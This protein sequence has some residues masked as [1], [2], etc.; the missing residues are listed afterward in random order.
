[1]TNTSKL[2]RELRK[3]EYICKQRVADCNSCAKAKLPELE[4]WTTDQ[5]YREGKTMVY[6][7]VIE[8]TIIRDALKKLNIPYLWEGTDEYAF[9]VVE[10]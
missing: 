1:M 10:L 5:S 8:G 9:E 6:F 2:F 4:V 7:D 3:E